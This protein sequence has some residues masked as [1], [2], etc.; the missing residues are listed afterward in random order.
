MQALRRMKPGSRASLVSYRVLTALPDC[1]AVREVYKTNP[2]R[3][4]SNRVRW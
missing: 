1:S 2:S 3:I 4:L